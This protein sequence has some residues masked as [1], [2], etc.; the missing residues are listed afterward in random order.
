MKF[1]SARSYYLYISDI[2]ISNLYYY[3]M[4]AT[5]TFVSLSELI[6]LPGEISI[7]CGSTFYD[8]PELEHLEKTAQKGLDRII[9]DCKKN[10][11]RVRV[12]T[13]ETILGEL[14]KGHFLQRISR[15]VFDDSGYGHYSSSQLYR[16]TTNK[17]ITFWLVANGS[18][19]S[20][21]YCDYDLALFE[22]IESL[23][24][25]N[26][27]SKVRELYFDYLVNKLKRYK[28]FNHK[29]E[30]IQDIKDETRGKQY[31]IER[32][33]KSKVEKTTRKITFKVD[34]LEDF[35]EL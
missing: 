14:V 4:S 31:S 35:P 10:K 26:N 2:T 9:N 11:T 34:S 17:G 19:G 25:K 6:A 23:V 29:Q 18:H 7:V 33:V 3:K 16:Y 28:V 5:K 12:Y 24:R 30:A 1:F 27:W 22:E 32:F 15:T 8:V 13:T 20:C 21:S